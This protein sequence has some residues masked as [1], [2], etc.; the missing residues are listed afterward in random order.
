MDAGAV[1][2]AS[3]GTKEDRI[4]IYPR[5]SEDNSTTVMI[6]D[7]AVKVDRAALEKYVAGGDVPKELASAISPMLPNG[8]DNLTGRTSAPKLDDLRK[9]ARSIGSTM[10]LNQGASHGE[11]LALGR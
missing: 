1:A 10:G 4:V 2:L 5:L 3:L 8:G 6:G 9:G 11:R 7:R